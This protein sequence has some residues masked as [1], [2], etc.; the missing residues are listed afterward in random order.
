MNSPVRSRNGA[1][2]THVIDVFSFLREILLTE[3][4]LSYMG[5]KIPQLC[6]IGALFQWQ[7]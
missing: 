1:L 2:Y 5:G 4:Y 6:L 3:I 7:I